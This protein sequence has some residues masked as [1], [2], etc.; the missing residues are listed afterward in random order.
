MKFKNNIKLSF[1]RLDDVRRHEF[2]II[3]ASAGCL[4]GGPSQFFFNHP[5]WGR[6]PTILT[7]Y[8]FPGTPARNLQE[9]LSRIRYSAH[10]P[11]KSWLNISNCSL[12]LI[13][14]LSIILNPEI[15]LKK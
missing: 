6:P 12:M 9:E 15:K 4:Q 7:G 11:H 10:S 13:F 2:D 14:I 5:Q 8:L 3:V 1:I